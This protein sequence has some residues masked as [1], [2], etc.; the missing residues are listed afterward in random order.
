[1]KC[2]NNFSY[3]KIHKICL[4]IFNIIAH[5]Y[6]H[7]KYFHFIRRKVKG[8]L[9][10]SGPNHIQLTYNIIYLLCMSPCNEPFF[11]WN[12]HCFS[13]KQKSGFFTFPAINILWSV[14]G[15]ERIPANDGDF[16]ALL[17]KISKL[18]R[19]GNPSGDVLD[20]FPFLRYIMPGLAGYRERKAGT[21]SVQKFMRVSKCK[22]EY[23]RTA[24]S[25]TGSLFTFHVEKAFLRV[26]KH[27]PLSLLVPR[28]VGSS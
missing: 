9:C 6:A 15:G 16:M 2:I 18:F 7:H 4:T 19:T 24:W 12:V 25:I 20:V 17:Q 26:T 5:T 1:M 3:V 21:E 13:F 11:C 22:S 23:K 14:L 8:I 28:S 10:I 27:W